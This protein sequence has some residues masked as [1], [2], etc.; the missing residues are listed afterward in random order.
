MSVA[1]EAFDPS[2]VTEKDRS[3]TL[4]KL[5]GQRQQAVMSEFLRSFMKSAKVS[6]NDSV[7]IE[8]KGSAVPITADMD[9]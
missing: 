6:R 2:K 9:Q 5:Q 8:G 4:K 1:S 3:E 7:V